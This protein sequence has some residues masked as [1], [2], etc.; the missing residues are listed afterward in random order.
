MRRLLVLIA[1]CSSAC[2]GARDLAGPTPVT[3]VAPPAVAL[4]MITITGHV[5]ATNGGEPLPGLTADLGGPTILT[6]SSGTFSYHIGVGTGTR[7]TL[8]GGGIVPRSLVIATATT[9][10]VNVDAFGPGFDLAFYRL[11]ARNGFDAPST[12]QPL[13]RLPAA[14]KVYIRTI[15]EAGAAIDAGTLDTTAK[16][17]LDVAS[18]WTGGRFGVASIERGVETR[19]GQPGWL[20]VTWLGTVLPGICGQTVVGLDGGAMELN[21]LK[22]DCGCGGTRMTARNVKHELGH[23]FGF[24]HTGNASDLMSGIG[25]ATCDRMPSAREQLYAG[26][27]YGRPR[28]NV[29]PDAD[30]LDLQHLASFR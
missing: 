30:P 10:D 22:A 19:E 17:L 23:A 18:L 14:P 1:L 20:T 13:R 3:A 15:D 8:T 26:F 7:L 25:D 16:A 28:G 21:Y 2:E 24:F 9:H 4:P 5:S 12:L 27:A 29:D 11:L 6:D